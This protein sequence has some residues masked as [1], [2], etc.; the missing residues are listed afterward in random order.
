MSNSTNL[1]LSCVRGEFQ[2]N[3]P[4][5]INGLD[6][7]RNVTNIDD[8]TFADVKSVHKVT[9]SNTFAADLVLD[10]DTQSFSER[11]NFTITNGGAVTSPSIANFKSLVKVGDIVRY[12]K[13]G[14]TLPTFNRVSAGVNSG[15]LT[16][17]AVTSVAGVCDGTLPSGTI[18][19]NDFD[20]ITGTLKNAADPGYRI[21]LQN[22]YV[23]SINLLDSTYIV[24]K[25]IS[26]N[27]TGSTFTFL[28]SDLGDND[29]T[30]EPFTADTYVLTWQMGLKNLYDPVKLHSLLI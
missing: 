19:T 12:S 10:R 17:V 16:L 22:S 30:F 5:E 6:V 15:T 8:F 25:Q 20:V 28:L 4:L 9:G 2:L 14:G 26:K 23:S 21:K 11:S 18:T 1:T 7:G 29:L 13:P 27:I 24:R 3:E